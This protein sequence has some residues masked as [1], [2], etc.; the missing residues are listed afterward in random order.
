MLAY[1]I[2]FTI[3]VACGEAAQRGKPQVF[4]AARFGLPRSHSGM[5]LFYPLHL[6]TDSASPI[7]A[8]KNITEVPP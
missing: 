2:D 1:Q 6:L 5:P 7:S 8:S 3:P 4:R